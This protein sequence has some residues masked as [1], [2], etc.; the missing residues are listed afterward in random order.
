MLPL[1]NLGQEKLLYLKAPE[2]QEIAQKPPQT[3]HQK[4]YHLLKKQKNKLQQK[5]RNQILKNHLLRL[6]AFSQAKLLL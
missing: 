2:K 4:N 3:K 5:R 6:E 1:R